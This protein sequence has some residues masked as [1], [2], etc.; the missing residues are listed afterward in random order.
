MPRDQTSAAVEN[1]KAAVSGAS[2]GSNL[3]EDLRDSPIGKHVSLD[4]LSLSAESSVPP[5]YRCSRNLLSITWPSHCVQTSLI[6]H[7]QRRIL[8]S[9]PMG[10]PPSAWRAAAEK[11]HH[12]V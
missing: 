7:L 8:V 1:G 4:S 12:G 6:L 5:K 3:R 9:R 11:K 2:W 10:T